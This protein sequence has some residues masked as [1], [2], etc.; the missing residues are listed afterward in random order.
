MERWDICFCF[1]GADLRSDGADFID[2]KEVWFCLD[3][4]TLTGGFEDR[5]NVWSFV[6]PKAGGAE[7]IDI[8]ES[9]NRLSGTDLNTGGA[10]F[11][12]RWD[13]CPV[14]DLNTGSGGSKERRD[15]WFCFSL[16]SGVDFRDVWEVRR[17]LWLVLVALLTLT[18]DKGRNF[19]EWL[20]RDLSTSSFLFSCLCPLLTTSTYFCPSLSVSDLKSNS[21]KT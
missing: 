13:I 21:I 1:T 20:E 17:F 2:M 12:E 19:K 10:E 5:P 9:L 15:V 11:I 6:D 3:P 7:F 16:V 8:R 4:N 14:V 18:V